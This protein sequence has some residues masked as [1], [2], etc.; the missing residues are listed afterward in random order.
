MARVLGAPPQRVRFET[1]PQ[2]D[3]SPYIEGVDGEWHS[4]RTAHGREIERRKTSDPDELLF[5]LISDLTFSMARDWERERRIE[6]ED[7]RRQ[8]FRK[9]V[10]LLSGVRP[11][12]AKRKSEEYEKILGPYPFAVGKKNTGDGEASGSSSP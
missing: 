8:L 3:G 9:D 1:T 4:V 11:D 5:W 7:I 6:G 10:E 12:W 2:E